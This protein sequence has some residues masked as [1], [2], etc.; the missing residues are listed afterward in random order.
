MGQQAL[1]RVDLMEWILAVW[2]KIN[3]PLPFLR[4]GIAL[5]LFSPSELKWAGYL[6]IAVGIA[7]A[8]EWIALQLKRWIAQRQQLH[9][10]IARLNADEKTILKV[11]VQAGEQTFYL[12]PLR[13]GGV[14]RGASTSAFRR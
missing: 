13:A 8:V 9:R 1:I 12:D 6:F 10:S 14:S 3:K 4:V 5:V 7:G 2:N 11:P